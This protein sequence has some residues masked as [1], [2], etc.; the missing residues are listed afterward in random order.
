[1][2]DI[3]FNKVTNSWNVNTVDGALLVGAGRIPLPAALDHIEMREGS[4]VLTASADQGVSFEV[5]FTTGVVHF[6][7]VAMAAGSDGEQS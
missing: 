5:N 2:S 6:R 4:I 1:M 7:G 3:G